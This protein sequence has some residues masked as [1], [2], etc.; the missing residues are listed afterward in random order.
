MTEPADNLRRPLID[1]ILSIA[2]DKLILG[3]RNSDWT[4]LAPLLEED[5]AFSSLAQDEMAHAQALYE[6]AG[7]LT[8]RSADDLAF[9]RQPGEYRCAAV[10]ELPDEFD[11]ATAIARQFVCDHFELLRLGR[12]S[13]SAYRPLADLALRLRAEE[14]VHAE[15][16]DGWI[17]RLGRGTDGARERMQ[18]ALD[19]VRPHAP[20]L[21]EPVEGQETL[22]SAGLYPPGARDMFETWAEALQVVSAR[23]GLSLCLQRPR[24]SMRGGRRGVHTP[25]LAGLLDEMSEVYRLE[26]GAAW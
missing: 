6:L 1:L 15:H 4:G 3:H 25:H 20:S 8:D 18:R 12:L 5:I 14:Q 2:D 23:A 16:A 19:A 17:V 7:R 21:L 11:W 13:G 26:P 24:A 22:E 9:G 10:V